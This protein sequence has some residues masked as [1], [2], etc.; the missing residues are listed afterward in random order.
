MKKIIS[1]FLLCFLFS[2]AYAA[3]YNSGNLYSCDLRGYLRR[4]DLLPSYTH[5]SDGSPSYNLNDNSG[6]SIE[7]LFSLS[8][9]L[10]SGQNYV[11]NFDIDV[12]ICPNLVYLYTSTS[13][14]Y[15]I[16]EYDFSDGSIS[17]S[18]S[19]TVPE[20]EDVSFSRLRLFF[21]QDVGN[22]DTE[23]YINELSVQTIGDFVSVDKYS[24][25]NPTYSSSGDF[26]SW[27]LNGYGNN[28]AIIPMRF[29]SLEHS[30][31]E[32]GFTVSY[33]SDLKVVSQDVVYQIVF[34]L[35]D[36]YDLVENFSCDFSS[37]YSTSSPGSVLQLS[38]GRFLCTFIIHN[39]SSGKSYD[40]HFSYDLKPRNNAAFVGSSYVKLIDFD[41]LPLSWL[42]E[43]VDS[44]VDEKTFAG[45]VKGLFNDF[46]SFLKGRDSEKDSDFDKSY[47]PG[48]DAAIDKA[49]S[50]MDL[51]EDTED[52]IWNSFDT[53]MTEI[54]LGSLSI[55]DSI[56][57]SVLW[58]NNV[59]G[60]FYNALPNDLQF[61]ITFPMFMGLALV[62]IGRIGQAISSGDS[63][64]R[65]KDR[66]GD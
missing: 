8:P 60:Y 30:S 20:S 63:H 48:V 31:F 2:F 64:M 7:I 21:P 36:E 16:A 46:K 25:L 24:F 52:Q 65:K 66:G 41:V 38:Q 22:S 62:V 29:K 37:S 61:L 23:F 50:Q 58:I 4:I 53:S 12:P 5:I 9:K 32:F 56:F 57:G 15:R 17:G 39:F 34:E 26:Q 42:P 40:F 13:T 10:I 11:F 43:Y 3:D 28:N 44:V 59:W 6:N 27:V 49:E 14:A 54:N 55:P 35:P 45:F 47:N 1:I 19:F 33:K 51:I 18:F